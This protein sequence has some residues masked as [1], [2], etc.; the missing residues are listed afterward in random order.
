MALILW[1]SSPCYGMEF[2]G[3]VVKVRAGDRLD[4]MQDGRPRRIRLYGVECSPRAQAAARAAKFTQQMAEARAVHVRVVGQDRDGLPLARVNFVGGRSLNQELLRA[5]MARWSKETAPHERIL[6]RHESEARLARRGLWRD[7]ANFKRPSR[8]GRISPS[9]GGHRS[10]LA[11]K[12][13][14][15]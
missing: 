1:A 5:G 6:A 10:S 7:P 3:R 14:R 11:R 4:V 8:S 13:K 9:K 2:F 15:R 12:R